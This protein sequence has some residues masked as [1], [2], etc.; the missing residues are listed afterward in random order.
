MQTSL[1]REQLQASFQFLPDASRLDIQPVAEGSTPI[2]F[3]AGREQALPDMP[4]PIKPATKTEALFLKVEAKK[5]DLLINLIGQLV[6]QGASADL[7]LRMKN[8]EQLEE[9]FSGIQQLVSDMRESALSLRMPPV[10]E[11][12]RR[13]QHLVWDLGQSLDKQIMLKISG[14][15]TELDKGMLI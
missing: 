2:P 3:I 5:L 4:T 13:L 6:T 12:F 15:D 9:T 7:Q 8:Y 1:S 14:G 11:S 10:A